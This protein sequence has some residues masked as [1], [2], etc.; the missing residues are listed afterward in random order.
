[1]KCVKC[2]MRYPRY[3]IMVQEGLSPK[4]CRKCVE[5]LASLLAELHFDCIARDLETGELFQ[6]KLSSDAPN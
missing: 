4:L 2:Q 5:D 3:A 6:V 1:M